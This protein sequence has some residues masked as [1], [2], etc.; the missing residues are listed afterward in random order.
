[1]VPFEPYANIHD[2]RGQ[3]TEIYQ[4]QQADLPLS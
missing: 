3:R 4:T 2:F 1:M